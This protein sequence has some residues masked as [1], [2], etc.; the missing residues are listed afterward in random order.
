VNPQLRVLGLEIDPERVAEARASADP[1]AVDFALGGFDL[2]NALGAE[3]ARV[4][5]CMNV[6]RQYDEAAVEHALALIAEG[7][8]PG[9]V[10]LEGTSDPTGRLTVFDVWRRDTTGLTHEALVFA[11]NFR[12]YVSPAEFR[13]RAPKRLIH[14]MLDET[15]ARFFAD[16]ERAALMA[17]ASFSA[18]TAQHWAES[19]RLLAESDAWPVD[20]RRRVLERGFLALR[21]ELR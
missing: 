1:P 2:V 5:R 19:A 10:L 13:T 14:R 17:R 20:L 21:S 11:T 4:V 15:P 9:G 7:I 16:W 3:R 6:L 8:E 12:E 18:G